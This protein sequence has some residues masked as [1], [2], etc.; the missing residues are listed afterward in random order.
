MRD[1]VKT[2]INADADKK[3]DMMNTMTT[4]DAIELNKAGYFL[5]L[6][7]GKVTDVTKETVVRSKHVKKQMKLKKQSDMKE[8]K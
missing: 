6:E 3:K 8:H 7:D 2:F 4:A 5:T 1:Y